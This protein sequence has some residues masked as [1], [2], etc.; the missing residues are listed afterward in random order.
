MKANRKAL[1][2]SLSTLG[3][4]LALTSPLSHAGACCSPGNIYVG[5]FGGGGSAS[6]FHISQFGTA[7]Y[8]E[9][10]GGP[11]AV[12][13]FGHSHSGSSNLWGA[14]V[15][16]QWMEIRA[17]SC[18]TW[19]LSPAVEL[20][21]YYLS[22]RTF[23]AHDVNNNTD[24]LPEHDFAVNYPT[25]TGVFLGNAVLNL[26]FPCSRF[27]PYVGLGIGSALT[28]V[29]HATATQVSPPEVGVNHFNSRSTDKSPTFAGQAKLGLNVDV[30]N[31]VSLFV[32][33]RYLYLASTSYEFGSTVYANHVATSNW[34]VKMD[35][36]HYNIGTLGLQYSF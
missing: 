4:M 11:L 29:S 36:R 15:G 33:Y 13:A 25:N 19:G 16:Y 24:R 26:N 34:K 27:H 12:N 31:S 5:I 35:P 17:N 9:A 6:N 21:G 10:E 14:H 30:C 18:S 8:S 7:F 23:K 22:K 28:K 1:S 32:E 20:E 3:M 2:V